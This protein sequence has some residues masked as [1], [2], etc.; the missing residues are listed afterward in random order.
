VGSYAELALRLRRREA[1]AE[2]RAF[3]AIKSLPGTPWSQPQSYVFGLRA[4]IS[5]AI[6]FVLASIDRREAPTEPT[7]VLGQAKR[8]ARAEVSLDTVL[9]RVA[10]GERILGELLAEE[11][12]GSTTET[13][14]EARRR[15]SE[16]VDELMAAVAK[17]YWAELAEMKNA[18]TDSLF[19]QVRRLLSGCD[20]PES[21]GDYRL[22]RWHVGVASEAALPERNLIA[23]A[24]GAGCGVLTVRDGYE[25]T[26]GWFGC[27]RHLGAED[28]MGALADRALDAGR[29]TVGEARFGVDGWRLS[30]DE[31][32]RALE[33]P[34]DGREG[35]I[36]ARDVL[37]AIAVRRDPT[38]TQSMIA[39]YIEPLNAATGGRDLARTLRVYLEAGQNTTAAAARL[40]VNRHTVQRRVRIAERLLGQRIEDCHAEL[41]VA[42][43]LAG[44][45]SPD[46]LA[47]G[48]REE[49]V[50]RLFRRQRLAD[51]HS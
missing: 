29:V 32:M 12:V 5:E 49:P 20:S 37:L 33:A 4:A 13:V 41:S 25:R 18:P 48:P 24:H 51:A 2:E 14:R 23:V 39:S 19:P 26:W 22:D 34:V 43:Q 7:A 44:D 40:S 6:D 50:S 45:P 9:R 16:S 38:L 17:E 27:T 30:H 35:V 42:L 36:R 3:L 21:V 8:A 28:L 15:M 46:Q 31:A 10:A 1:E 11:A 47:R